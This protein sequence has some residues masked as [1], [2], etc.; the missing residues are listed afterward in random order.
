[1]VLPDTSLWIRYLRDPQAAKKHRLVE[2][3]LTKPL[4]ELE[5]A[6]CGVILYE[7]IQGAQS[8]KHDADILAIRSACEYFEM[9]E[10]DYLKAGYLSGELI[11]RHQFL[12]MSDILIATCALTNNL[13]VVTHD[14]DFG[15]IK[16]IQPALKWKL[17]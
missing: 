11:R 15:R 8:K 1:M 6:T 12:A 16:K 2:Q 9:T 17:M 4:S 7:L 3:Y 14:Q 5:V 13:I 10:M